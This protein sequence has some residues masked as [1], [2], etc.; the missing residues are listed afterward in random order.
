[1]DATI[2]GKDPRP[3]GGTL[4]IQPLPGIGD[5]IW[6]LPHLKSIAARTDEKTVTLLTKQ[7]SKA[8]MLLSGG[9]YVRHVLWLDEKR[10]RGPLGGWRLGADLKPYGF[11]S[12]WI[13]HMS[14]RYGLAAV[15]AGIG[16]RIGYGIGW[17]D[18]FLTTG[19][20]L[21]RE[22]KP[23]TAIEKAN[24]LLANHSV[25]KVE[26]APN[27]TYPAEI[28]EQASVEFAALPRPWISLIIGASE[29]FKQWGAENF[30]ALAERLRQAT[31]GTLFLIGGPQEAE[32]AD[33]IQARFSSPDWIVP[34]TDRSLLQAGALTALSDLAVGNDTGLLNMAAAG[35]TQ[36]IGLFGGSPSVS[37]DPRIDVIAPPGEIKYGSDRMDEIAV[38]SVAMRALSRLSGN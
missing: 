28:L 37:E 34:A 25:P 7:R 33:K 23:L 35:N 4:V 12:V 29:R 26:S 5:A 14:P 3:L 11:S 16:D 1:M 13:L 38:E 31:G 32:I 15:R 20:A 18:A 22:A 19:H 36:S 9:S 2:A 10:H 17:Q 6:H 27:L 30:G 24:R 8:D 21:P